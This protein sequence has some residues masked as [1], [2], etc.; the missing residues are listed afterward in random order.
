MRSGSPAMR[1][2]SISVNRP[3]KTAG[4][5]C[6]HRRL[7]N[8]AGA[9]LGPALEGPGRPPCGCADTIGGAANEQ[10][11]MARPSN[12]R[13]DVTADLCIAGFS[14]QTAIGNERAT[15]RRA[16]G[17]DSVV[18]YRNAC[19][20]MSIRPRGARARVNRRLFGAAPR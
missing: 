19:A 1:A 11:T 10:T 4:P 2:T 20:A 3:P 6:R 5:I 16:D 18:E 13:E 12:V 15:V 9:K 14:E 17:R 7:E 8:G